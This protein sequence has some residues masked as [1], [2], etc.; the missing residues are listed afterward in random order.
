MAKAQRKMTIAL[1]P[2]SIGVT[3]DQSRSIELAHYFGFE[4]VQPFPKELAGFSAAQ[5]DE[6]RGELKAKGLV[7]AASGLPVQFRE[8]EAK[9]REDMKAWPRLVKALERAG[10][11]R[12]GTWLMPTHDSL[13]YLE[14]FKQTADRLREAAAVAGDHGLRLGLEYVGTKTLWS[15]KK[16]AFVHT[17][18]ETKELLG[19][20][21]Q[22]NV[23]FVL[24]SWHWWTSNETKQDILTLENKDVV[25]CDLNDAPKGIPKER[26]HD[27]KRAVP[28]STGVID[29][30]GF[31]EGLVEIGYDGPIRAEPF[32][33][34][35]NDMED[36]PA[37]AKTIEAMRRAVALAG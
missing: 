34:E 6:L 12:I 27:L 9:F 26:Q 32:S 14:N 18:A 30:K 7:W 2:G 8:D 29:V 1:T 22:P 35:L 19:E 23:G 20:I 15:L 4:S 21:G 36:E 3:A 25:S 10:V 13:T 16:Y 5:N 33:A 28:L 37:C 11:D 17:M 24:D 31:L